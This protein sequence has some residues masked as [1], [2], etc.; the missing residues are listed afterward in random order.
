MSGTITF[1]N[2]TRAQVDAML[3]EI[4][5]DSASAVVEVAPDSYVIQG[6]GIKAHAVYGETEKAVGVEVIQKPFYVS[7]DMIHSQI[8]KA[9]QAAPAS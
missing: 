5:K 4:R 9:L 3:A 6:H 8:A 2:V 7:M 1:P